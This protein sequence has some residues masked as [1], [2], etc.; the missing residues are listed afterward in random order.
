LIAL[1]DRAIYLKEAED[2]LRVYKKM[3]EDI[4]SSKEKIERDRQKADQIV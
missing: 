4:R 2:K 1:F 3:V